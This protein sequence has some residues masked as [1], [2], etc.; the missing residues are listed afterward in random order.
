MRPFRSPSSAARAPRS[1]VTLVEVVIAIFVLTVGVLGIISL[2]PTGYRLGQMAFARSV[3]SLAARDALPRILAD[4]KASPPRLNYPSD[5]QPL[6]SIAER[7]RVGVVV[8]INSATTLACRTRGGYNPTYSSLANYYLVI[9][10]GAARGRLYRISSS[11]GNT[12]T[13]S[14]ATFRRTND[15]TGDPIRIGDHYAIIGSTSSNS[16]CW[17]SASTPSQAS[18]LGNSGNR[19]REAATHGTVRPRREN[20]SNPPW[21][22]SYGC[23][24]SAPT[25]EL[26]NVFRI[27]VFV[28]R[29]FNPGVIVD[30]QDQPAGHFVTYIT[31]SDD[32]S[33]MY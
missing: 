1:G 11:S 16:A 23:I 33:N 24:L 19:T 12:L 20:G 5:G 6:C 22:Y 29:A 15:K 32:Y 31:R 13:C 4:L 8:G 7:D 3:A 21:E 17:P 28:Y 2:F 30:K 14:G 27:D 26:R 9:T 18:F 10:S 25:L